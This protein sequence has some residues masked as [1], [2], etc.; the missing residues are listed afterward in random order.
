MANIGTNGDVAGGVFSGLSTTV[1]VNG[2]TII[3]DGSPV[4]SHGLSP[5]SNATMIATKAS[6]VINGINP[7]GTGDVATCGHV[8]TGTGTV[9]I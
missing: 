4:A 2:K 9:T 6:V 5:H 8:L 7:C 3:L 1:F